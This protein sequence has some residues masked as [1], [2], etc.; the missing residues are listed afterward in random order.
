MPKKYISDNAALMKEWDWEKN[1]D[2]DPNQLLY[3]SGKKA[4]WICSKG[5]KYEQSIVKRTSR[6]YSCPVCSGHKTLVGYN[7]L[8]TRAPE[9]AKEWHPTKNNLLKPSDVTF[10]SNKK[11][12]WKCSKCGY[13]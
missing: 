8:A 9:I 10:G 13:S 11:A 4:W 3:N 5:H 7:D 1:Q 12:W 2:L 6:G